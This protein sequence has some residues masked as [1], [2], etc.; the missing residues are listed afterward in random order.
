M[1]E[2]GDLL[3]DLRG[4]ESLREAAERIGISHTYLSILEKGN[5][6]RSKKPIKPT[7]DTLKLLS[8]AYQYPYEIL[9]E[10][11][12]IIDE[13]LKLKLEDQHKM[14]LLKDFESLDEEGQK[15]ITHMIERLKKND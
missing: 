5:D 15:I 12:D 9:L 8:K 14:K 2:L 7:S 11:A 13:D 6:L 1:S 3:R 10:K 4:K